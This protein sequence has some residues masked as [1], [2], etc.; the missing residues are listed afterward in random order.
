[1]KFTTI[2]VNISTSCEGIEPLKL[3]FLAQVT[4]NQPS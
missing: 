3:D 1:M 4:Y 2:V